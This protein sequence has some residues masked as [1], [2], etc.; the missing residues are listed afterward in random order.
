MNGICGFGSECKIILNKIRN[1]S[2][3]FPLLVLIFGSCRTY[4]I[5]YDRFAQVLYSKYYLETKYSTSGVIK[6]LISIRYNKPKKEKEY[7][8]LVKSQA[9]SPRKA[10]V[11]KVITDT[12]F[13]AVGKLISEDTKNITKYDESYNPYFP[14]ESTTVIER[15]DIVTAISK[16]VIPEEEFM[17]FIKMKNQ[18]DEMAEFKV[19]TASSYAIVKFSKSEIQKFWSEFNLKVK[20]I[21]N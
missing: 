8:I 21:A 12:H 15:R 2:S 6:S 18:Y 17:K 1:I 5:E 14:Y 3:V 9:R 20:M 13:E 16:F 11:D 10:Q 4:Q 7:S 19:Y